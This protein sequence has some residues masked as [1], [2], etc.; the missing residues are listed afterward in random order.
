MPL[1]TSWMTDEHLMFS[2]TIRRFFAD[3]IL[4]NEPRWEQAG[5]VEPSL[6]TR[7]GAMGLLGGGIPAEYGGLDAE[8]A[9]SSGIDALIC[10]EQ[11]RVNALGWGF[12]VQSIVK[13]YVVM[14]GTPEQKAKWLP[15]L[16]TGEAI[17]S[18]VMSEPGAGSDLKGIRT[19]AVR[20]GN[21]LVLDGSKIFISNGQTSN[22]ML[23]V[24]R[25]GDTG[26]ARDI[27]LVAVEPEQIGA[28]VRGANLDKIGMK[29][30]DTSELR[31]DAV[32]VPAANILGGVE[33]RGFSQLMQELPWERLLIAYW[34]LGAIEGA[35]DLTRTYVAERQAFGKRIMDFQNTRFALARCKVK[36]EVTRAFVDKCMAQYLAGD[37]DAAT[38]S[39]AKLWATE[40]QGEVIDTCLQLHG[41]YGYM[42]EYPISQ[43][44]TNARVQRI[45][46]G[47]SEIM[48]ELISRSLDQ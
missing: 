36:L 21:D 42:T 25:T 11:G 16:A 3:E 1:D 28:V 13:N 22:F 48:L 19:R 10:M 43:F 24:A 5:Q 34:S 32:R 38:A 9:N 30:Q 23:V 14:H 46:G 8:S 44:Y 40:A 17:P 2:E 20:D 4:P 31:F 41:G 7:A 26:S 6:W 29:A 12:I 37:L 39:I 47:T 18:I 27:S 33:G 45:Y 15:M 35:L